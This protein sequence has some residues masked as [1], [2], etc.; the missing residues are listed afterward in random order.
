LLVKDLIEKLK[1]LPQ[2]LEV[3]TPTSE[4]TYLVVNWLDVIPVFN[5]LGVCDWDEVGNCEVVVI[6]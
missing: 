3:V 6:Q 1:E 2:D 5:F 4:F